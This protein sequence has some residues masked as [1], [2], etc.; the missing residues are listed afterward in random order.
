MSSL[1]PHAFLFN[2]DGQERSATMSGWRSTSRNDLRPNVEARSGVTYGVIHTATVMPIAM[3]LEMYDRRNGLFIFEFEDGI[4]NRSI[5]LSLSAFVDLYGMIDHDNI[6]A[7]E[8]SF[9]LN[10]AAI[11]RLTEF[12]LL[13]D[14]G[15]DPSRRLR[16]GRGTV[17]AYRSSLAART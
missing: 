10:D 1:C 16:I 3:K 4:V 9:V 17:M 12:A 11:K 13:Q 2:R 6:Y 15:A 14:A 7:A 5:S 8:S